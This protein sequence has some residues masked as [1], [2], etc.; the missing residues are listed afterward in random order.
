MNDPK[1]ITKIADM[2]KPMRPSYSLPESQS[3]VTVKAP[4]SAL[5]VI[6][7]VVVGAALF[8]IVQA[9]CSIDDTGPRNAGSTRRGGEI[10]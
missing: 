10:F 3:I 6:A 9:G 4:D 5:E 2:R 1:K 7:I 8:V